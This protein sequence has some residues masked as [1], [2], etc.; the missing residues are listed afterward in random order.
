MRLILI[1]QGYAVLTLIVI[2]FSLGCDEACAPAST[3][4]DNIK[5]ESFKDE[6]IKPLGLK[7][8]PTSFMISQNSVILAG[9]NDLDHTVVYKIDF[10][11]KLIWKM[12]LNK[13]NRKRSPS[14]AKFGT[15]QFL[16]STFSEP[17]GSGFHDLSYFIL[18]NDGKIN[19]YQNV[20]NSSNE[21]DVWGSLLSIPNGDI[22][23]V[24][25]IPVPNTLL[26]H[27]LK[28]GRIN[29]TGKVIWLKEIDKEEHQDVYHHRLISAKNG[30]SFLT[31]SSFFNKYLNLYNFDFEGNLIFK[32]KIESQAEN[33][34]SILSHYLIQTDD[35]GFLVSFSDDNLDCNG[36]DLRLYKI[37]SGGQVEWSRRYGGIQT[38]NSRG[39]LQCKDNTY[40]ILSNVNKGLMITK[41]D[42]F[43]NVV[44]S[45]QYGTENYYLARGILEKENGD[46]FII[47]A[48]N[49]NT[50]RDDIFDT[51]ILETHANGVPKK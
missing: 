1:G 3:L 51:A 47:A 2:S 24:T 29:K 44:W 17:I 35:N 5:I 33:E 30:I 32:T 9:L 39:L 19:F 13:D 22:I 7:L 48:T 18:N 25:S 14:I 40:I 8:S 36:Y 43:G 20:T 46:L 6:V 26:S 12:D 21:A 38:D 37:N 50:G 23:F 11:G 15:D 28:M 42:K 31:I 49:H 16:V 10:N 34:I 45:K 27:T 41:V 4:F